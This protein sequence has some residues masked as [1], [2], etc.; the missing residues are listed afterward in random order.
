MAIEVGDVDAGLEH[1]L[2]LS[3]ELALHLL[4]AGV[5]DGLARDAPYTAIERDESR[6][7]VTQQPQR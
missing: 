4:G 6:Y 1:A 2:D 3:T 7:V 5:L